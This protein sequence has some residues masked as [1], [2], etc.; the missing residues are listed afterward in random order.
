MPRGVERT[1]WLGG[2]DTV[3]IGTPFCHLKI[4]S[5]PL[6]PTDLQPTSYKL[7]A[8]GSASA[9]ASA[10]LQA[11]RTAER[12]RERRALSYKYQ[13]YMPHAGIP[14][15]Q[16]GIPDP[17]PPLPLPL[18]TAYAYVAVATCGECGLRAVAVRLV[19]SFVVLCGFYCQLY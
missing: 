4:R 7:Q 14:N 12:E 3:V 6:Q 16:P 1:T 13:F 9:S 17:D 5:A 8:T 11:R 19:A 10:S 15:R 18:R 2:G